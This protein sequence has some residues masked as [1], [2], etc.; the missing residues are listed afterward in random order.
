[1]AA[2][3]AIPSLSLPALHELRRIH[4]KHLLEVFAGPETKELFERGCIAGSFADAATDRSFHVQ[5]V[6]PLGIATLE[7]RER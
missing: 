2:E 6:T 5:S 7:A 1:M 4:T 3:P